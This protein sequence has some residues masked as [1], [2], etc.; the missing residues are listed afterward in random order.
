MSN[1]KVPP[2]VPYDETILFPSICKPKRAL[3][4]LQ[5]TLRAS[6]QEG[7]TKEEK[8]RHFKRALQDCIAALEW[9]EREDLSDEN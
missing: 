4:F 7:D 3:F 2:S 1:N 6:K 8:M 5:E 9:K